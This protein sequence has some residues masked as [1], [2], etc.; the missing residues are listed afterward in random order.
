[1]APLH[2]S[3]CTY[4]RL[5]SPTTASAV[6]GPDG[7]GM[8]SQVS[9]HRLQ[10]N[11]LHTYIHPVHIHTYIIPIDIDLKINPS[12]TH[13]AVPK[14]DQAWSVH[15]GRVTHRLFRQYSSASPTLFLDYLLRRWHRPQGLPINV[16][17]LAR[18]RLTA[19]LQSYYSGYSGLGLNPVPSQ[20]P[21]PVKA[22]WKVP[23]DSSVSV[24]SVW[25]LAPREL[26]SLADW[27]LAPGS[28]MYIASSTYLALT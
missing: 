21:R 12:Q 6:V 9:Q 17:A 14:S 3:A 7:M 16:R 1:M 4:Q 5:H 8:E 10:C 23:Q 18:P 27:L 19:Q 26:S 22:Q 2:L 13:R 28:Y 24:E 20:G 15:P 11:Y 25:P